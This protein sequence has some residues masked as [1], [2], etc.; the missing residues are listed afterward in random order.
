MVATFNGLHFLLELLTIPIAT[1]T[2]ILREKFQVRMQEINLQ[3]F[4]AYNRKS[5]RIKYNNSIS[6]LFWHIF[7]GN[8][9]HSRLKIFL[10]NPEAISD[11]HCERFYQEIKSTLG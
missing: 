8:F 5:N 9:Q 10:Q 4:V 2:E 1:I 11:E 3:D 6:H 7:R